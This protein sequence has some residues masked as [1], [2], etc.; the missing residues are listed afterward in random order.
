MIVGDVVI[1]SSFVSYAGIFNK[2]YRN[3]MNDDFMKFIRDNHV[4]VSADPNPVKI[5]TPESVIALW[6]K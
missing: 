1:A 6:S 3:I 4:P 2:K 5:L